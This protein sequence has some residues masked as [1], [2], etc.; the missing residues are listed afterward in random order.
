[1]Q[2]WL[3]KTK[4]DTGSIKIR[5]INNS[6]IYIN[7]SIIYIHLFLQQVLVALMTAGSLIS[8]RQVSWQI[9]KCSDTD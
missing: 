4:T 8:P 2:A 1:M 3:L 7:N 5:N 9:P 6:I